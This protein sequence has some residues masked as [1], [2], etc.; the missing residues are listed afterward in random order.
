MSAISKEHQKK[1]GNIVEE[2]FIKENIK[3]LVPEEKIEL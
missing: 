3:Q 1:F 2:F